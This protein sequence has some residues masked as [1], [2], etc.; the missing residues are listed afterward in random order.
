MSDE[1]TLRLAAR[2]DA[3]DL[4]HLHP[5]MAKETENIELCDELIAAGVRGLLDNPILGFYV[6]AE[7]DGAVVGSLMVATEWSDWR[8]GM[9]WWIQSVYVLPAYRRQG[10][11][12]RL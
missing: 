1:M 11:Y 3:N 10:I 5:E 12:R 2:Q 8:N 9:F 4:A 7:F 6:V